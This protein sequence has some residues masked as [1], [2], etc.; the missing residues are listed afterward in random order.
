[1]KDSNKR[2]VRCCH[3][4]LLLGHFN[5]SK[6]LVDSQINNDPTLDFVADKVEEILAF[7]RN[8]GKTYKDEELELC[9]E[10]ITGEQ[11]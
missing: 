11:V 9:E 8:E 3:I 10:L 2:I 4:L 1:M 7:L 5:L 6:T